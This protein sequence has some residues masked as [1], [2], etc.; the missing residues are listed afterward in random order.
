[1]PTAVDELTPQQR[2]EVA[3]AY[4]AQPSL[5]H[6]VH[7]MRRVLAT[8]R[9]AV[10][11]EEEWLDFQLKLPAYE[12]AQ[13]HGV[14]LPRLHGYWPSPREVD[15][16]A[17]PDSFV[18]KGNTG[19]MARAVFLLQRLG[20][21]RFVDMAGGDVLTPDDI[22]DRMD[23][24]L[25]AGRVRGVDVFA[26]DLLTD[27]S[28]SRP[29]A[30][31][32]FYCFHGTVGLSFTRTTNASRRSK[33]W[34]YR[35]FDTDWRDVGQAFT[36]L[37]VDAQLPLPRHPEEM[38]ATA[39]RLS[40]AVPR[41]FLRIDLYDGARGAVFGEV[42]VSPGGPHVLSPELDRR[43]GALWEDAEARLAALAGR[44]GALPIGLVG[45]G[46]AVERLLGRRPDGR[47]G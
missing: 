19:T 2:Y 43:L 11:Y 47:A 12:F 20:S 17:L 7:A 45:T 22:A 16:D 9:G 44:A 24:L 33:D 46:V 31:W 38:L 36:D 39:A 32:R 5:H 8:T 28:G 1:M 4:L 29:A 6:R 27:A 26:E 21:G 40:A 18:L 10:R 3:L 41:P 30:D 34:R 13:R 35:F 15:W 25:A 14:R 42:T 23:A 37:P